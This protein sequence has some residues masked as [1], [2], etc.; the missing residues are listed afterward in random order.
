[1]TFQASVHIYLCGPVLGVDVQSHSGESGHFGYVS[2]NDNA[3][4]NPFLSRSSGC[5][6]SPSADLIRLE[7]YV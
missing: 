5:S 7:T 3:H 2:H 1:M 6:R 4:R